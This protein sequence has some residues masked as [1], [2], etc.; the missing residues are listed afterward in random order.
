MTVLSPIVVLFH[1]WPK[2]NPVNVGNYVKTALD[3]HTV[4]CHSLYAPFTFSFFSRH[5]FVFTTLH[6]FHGVLNNWRWCMFWSPGADIRFR[7]H[8]AINS[9]N[10]EIYDL[11]ANFGGTASIT[12]VKVK[13][14]I[15]VCCQFDM[16]FP[17]Y[18]E[19]F[20]QSGHGSKSC[21]APSAYFKGF[22]AS[23]R[24]STA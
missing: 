16:D 19:I 18:L 2:R 14:N 4:V 13:I 12:H 22:T 9:Y 21:R 11:H 8:L 7:C 10:L 20:W 5:V 3:Y 24:G 15:V 17:P 23:D 1:L 6:S